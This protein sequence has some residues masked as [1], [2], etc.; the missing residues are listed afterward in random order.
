VVGYPG[1][2][3][4]RIISHA[5][6]GRRSGEPTVET[7]RGIATYLLGLR[8]LLRRPLTAVEARALVR[9][10]ERDRERHFLDVLEHGVFAAARSPY[11]RLLEHVGLSHA[12]VAA[13]VAEHGLEGAL[14][15]LHDEGVRVSMEEFKR[16]GVIERPG[17]RFQVRPEDFDNALCRGPF[18]VRTSGSS[19]TPSRVGFSLERQ[20]LDAAYLRVW[21]DALGLGERPMAIWRG[22]PPVQSG[23]G[24]VLQRAG[25]G[26]RVDRWFAQNRLAVRAETLRHLLFTWVT[27]LGARACGFAFPRPEYVHQDDAVR[28]AQWLAR[29]RLEGTPAELDTNASS[30]VR[31]CLAARKNGLDISGT[32]MRLT[33]EPLTRAKERVVREAGCRPYCFYG[34]TELGPLALQ[35]ASSRHRD[36][37]HLVTGKLAMI[38]REKP[39][40]GER[41]VG[42][43]LCTSLLRSSP[44]LM[45]NVELGDH[46]ELERRACGCE[47]GALGLDL[48]LHHLGSHDKLTSEALNYL[49]SDLVSLVEEVLPARFGGEPTHYQL[50]EEEEQGIPVVSVLASPS[51]G[52]IDEA[53]L[54]ATVHAVLDAAPGGA[55]LSDFWKQARTVRVVRREPY[56]GSSAKIQPLHV[57][58]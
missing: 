20:A 35:C 54:I 31:V 32:V 8:S 2:V 12:R 52:V 43:L 47:L 58:R 44:K 5:R 9:D 49:G 53:A 45:I 13:M 11:R 56:R 14:G 24:R 46:A 19:G 21:H 1:H 27:V 26:L 50:V 40:A 39:I 57:R 16:G 36:E 34:M 23:I 51:V 17:L 22:V 38:Q 28:I 55:L 30:G 29:R 3:I 42:A 18:E 15:T 25:A 48:L 33:G 10:A 4:P 7:M 41:T 6:G 37:M